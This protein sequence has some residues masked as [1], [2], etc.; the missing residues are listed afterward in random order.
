MSELKQVENPIEWGLYYDK[1][2][3]DKVIAGKDTEIQRL[4]RALWITRAERAKDM[5]TNQVFI[6]SYLRKHKNSWLAKDKE[7]AGDLFKEAFEIVERKCLKKAE[8]YK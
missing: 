2:E 4:R 6:E 5:Q 1:S 3:A 8:E 7:L